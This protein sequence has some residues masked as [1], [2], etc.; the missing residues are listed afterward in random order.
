MKFC[1]AWLAFVLS[2]VV[3]FHSHYVTASSGD[4]DNNEVV[5]D[6]HLEEAKAIF[7]WLSGRKDGF[8]SSKQEVRRAV[9][10]D[11]TSPLG[12]YAL[13]PI[14]KGETLVSV[15]WDALI[16]SD[17]P[18]D[19]H[20][21]SCGTIRNLARELRL[22][23]ESEFAPYATYLNNE[24]RNQIPSGWSDRGRAFLDDVIIDGKIPPAESTIW[25]DSWVKQ[26]D[27]DVDDE[28]ATKA[29]LMVI[30]RSDDSLVIP[31]YDSYNHRNGKWTNAGTEIVWDNKH[32]TTATRDI[33]VGEEIYL[34]YFLCPHC[35]GRALGYGTAGRW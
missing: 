19:G 25:F 13:M 7:H 15:P 32:I 8:V 31:A 2:V 10:G 17:D 16:E 28:F 27:G 30:Q 3:T 21:M 9:P 26:C 11:P 18:N 1:P 35:E 22:G 23:N 5:V 4:D 24:P 14:A 29:L 20:Q 34:S 33:E 6:Q 12:I